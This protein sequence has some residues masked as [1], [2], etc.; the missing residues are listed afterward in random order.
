MGFRNYFERAVRA[1]SIFGLGLVVGVGSTIYCLR[2]YGKDYAGTK[3]R[4]F[5]D[6]FAQESLERGIDIAGKSFG[7]VAGEVIEKQSRDI[8]KFVLKWGI[9][10][11]KRMDR[12]IRESNKRRELERFDELMWDKKIVMRI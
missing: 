3:T 5:L 7:N 1:T 11:Y 6:N 9:D 4:V 12:D 8:G 2:N 10:E